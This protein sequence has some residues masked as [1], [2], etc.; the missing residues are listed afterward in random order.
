M[1]TIYLKKCKRFTKVSYDITTDSG[2]SILEIGLITKLLSNSDKHD[3]Y[4]NINKGVEQKKSGVGKDMFNKAWKNLEEKKF[5]KTIKHRL[6]GKIAYQYIV[7]ALP[8]TETNNPQTDT[9]QQKTAGCSPQAENHQQKVT[10]SIQ[11][12]E[13]NN[14]VTGDRKQASNIDVTNKEIRNENINNIELNNKEVS[15][16][17]KNNKEV[18]NEEI[19]TVE[20]SNLHVDINNSIVEID[21][22]ENNIKNAI[23]DCYTDFIEDN[24][25]AHN[26]DIPI[27]LQE[28][29]RQMVDSY[30]LQYNI[31]PWHVNKDINERY[32]S[33]DFIENTNNLTSTQW[34]EEIVRYASLKYHHN[35]KTYYIVFRNMLQEY[36]NENNIDVAI[37]NE[38]INEYFDFNTL[39]LHIK[40]IDMKMFNNFIRDARLHLFHNTSIS[41]EIV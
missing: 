33:E 1:K 39:P 4:F 29:V 20:L 40:S 26:I 2:L 5:I 11:K 7:S 24:I 36:I 22:C 35:S 18:N 3:N 10:D 30:I 15:S 14:L 28:E 31:E 23:C 13:N 37:A 6:D 12:V 19:I 34:F 21:Q 25:I 9:D 16:K 17:D 32:L 8:I 27:S 38:K 41:H